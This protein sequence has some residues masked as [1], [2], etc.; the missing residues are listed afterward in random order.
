MK[1]VIRKK[2]KQIE[3]EHDVKILFAVESGS[4]AWGFPSKDS[5][6]DV[7]FV[8]VH[9]KDWYLSID[10]KR[11]VIE[12]PINELLD[13]SGWDLRKA[14]N[15][16]AKSNPS[17]LEW[18]RSPIVYS[19]E[20]TLSAELR[21]VGNEILS[22]KACIYHYLHMAKGNY[23][24]YLQGQEVKIKKYFYILRPILACMWIEKYNEI[25]PVLFD[26]LLEMQGLDQDFLDEV[27]HLLARKKQGDELDI[28]P[29]RKV[30]N[31]FIEQKIKFFEG[32]VKDISESHKTN[33]NE[34]NKLFRKTLEE[35]WEK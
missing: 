1:E 9:R 20:L 10:Q 22:K 19:D 4:R 33:M 13:F 26:H 35:S 2:L 24:D 21:K 28:E 17:L 5:D 34:L 27:N 8:Y 23:R 32:Y 6:Y 18:L 14:L 30:L 7:R 16:F 12:Y 25:P 11:G 3:E 31:E 15:L 29:K